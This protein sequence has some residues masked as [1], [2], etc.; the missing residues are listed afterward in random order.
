MKM[1]FKLH[2]KNV[3]SN[4]E[5]KYLEVLIQRSL[6]SLILK[7]EQAENKLQCFLLTVFCLVTF[8]IH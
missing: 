5:M 6:L 4:T 2:M 7:K 8:Q 3:Y 1:I